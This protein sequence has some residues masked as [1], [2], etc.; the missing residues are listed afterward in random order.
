MVT[1]ADIRKIATALPEVELGTFGRGGASTSFKVRGR[2]FA[3][4]GGNVVGLD[5][6]EAA[7]TLVIRIPQELRTALINTHPDR[8]FITPHYLTGGAVLTQLRRL[9][10]SD[11]PEIADLMEEAWRR[12]APKRLAATFDRTRPA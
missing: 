2:G 1:F 5:A 8:F 4:F 3:R 7:D 10:K 6:D 11:L 12:F 9:R